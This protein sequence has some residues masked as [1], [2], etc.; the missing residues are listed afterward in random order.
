VVDT[1][2]NVIGLDVRSADKAVVPL[3]PPFIL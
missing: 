2:L 1:A 3:L